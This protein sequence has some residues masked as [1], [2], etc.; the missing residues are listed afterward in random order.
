MSGIWVQCNGCREFSFPHRYWRFHANVPLRLDFIGS[1]GE[2]ERGRRFAKNVGNFPSGAFSCFCVRRVYISVYVGVHCRRLLH[3]QVGAHL[4]PHAA[5]NN[6]QP[7]NTP[8]SY[9]NAPR[10]FCTTPACVSQRSSTRQPSPEAAF[11]NCAFKRW[12]SLHMGSRSSCSILKGFRS[13]ET[14]CKPSGGF[15][16]ASFCEAV[17]IAIG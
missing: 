11:A 14:C 4:M 8:P 13:T 16:R 17:M 12:G 10:P 9:R 2:A 15:S 5:C 1:R 7:P 6:W 3:P